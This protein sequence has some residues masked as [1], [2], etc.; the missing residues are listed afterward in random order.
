MVDARPHRN[1][2]NVSVEPWEQ[3]SVG[4]C[5]LGETDRVRSD[6]DDDHDHDDRDNDVVSLS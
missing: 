1:S 2:N 5:S 3:G 4:G 6:D